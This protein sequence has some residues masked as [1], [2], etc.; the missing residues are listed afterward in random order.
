[1]TERQSNIILAL[2]IGAAIVVTCLLAYL[3][4]DWF[5][6]FGGT[7]APTPAPTPPPAG[8]TSWSEVEAAGKIVVGTSADYPPFAYYDENFQLTGLD[9]TLMREIGQRL[10]VDVEFEDKIF[11]SLLT[12]LQVGES[13][14]AIGA[15]AITP[16]RQGQVDF[17]DVYYVS[18]D[19][20]LARAD[21]SITSITAVEQMADKRVGV[22]QGSAFENWLQTSLVDTGLMPASNLLVYQKATD[23][24]RD[25]REQRVDLVVLDFA[26]AETAVANGGVKLVGQG[27]Q[28]QVFAIAVP[29]GAITLLTRINTALTDLRNSGRLAQ[30]IEEYIGLLPDQIPPTPP[31]QLTAVPPPQPT[32]TPAGCIDD[33]S[34]VQDL[35]YDDQNMTNPPTLQ[36]GQPFSKGWRVRNTGT[37]LWDATY[38]LAYVGGNT[39]AAQMGG[40]PRPVQ[41]IVQP[42]QTYDFYVDLFAPPVPGTYQGFWSMR[43]TAGKQFGDRVWVGIR[44][45]A[46]A[47]VTP[48]PTQTP[49]TDITFT[50]D[51]TT[52]RQGE[53]VAFNW[54]VR[55]ARAVYF[56]AQGQRWE[57][58]GVPPQGN[59]TVCP[60]STTTYYLRVVKADN[61][62]ETRQITVNVIPAPDAPLIE[63]FATNPQQITLGQCVSLQW[64]V[65]GEVSRIR[66]LANGGVLWDGAPLRG[67][68]QNCPEASGTVNYTLEAGGAG[69]SS[70]AQQ[71]VNVVT[72]ATATPVPTLPPQS[73]IIDAFAVTPGQIAVGECVTVNWSTSGGTSR[74][75]IRREGVPLVSNGGLNGSIQDC[76]TTVGTVRYELEAASI[77]NEF[78]TQS[79]LLGVSEPAAS[80]PLAD[81]SWAL[82]GLDESGLINGSFVGITFYADGTL[83]GDSGCNDYSSSYIVSGDNISVGEIASSSAFCA[84]PAGV[85]EQE[86]SYWSA[87]RSVVRFELQSSTLLVLFD[88]NGRER[89][90]FVLR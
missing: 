78:V 47:T 6:D 75:N 76:P 82:I 16:E 27:L 77:T 52:V 67:S 64:V 26:P 37:C 8:D 44:V 50:A 60:A 83:N 18:Q 21:S 73:P 48:Q 39:P 15:I 53:C 9:I 3:W 74:V 85:M 87:L 58:N 14:A 51:K 23:A 36:P 31:P 89:L 54:N 13:H 2:L 79:A 17:S 68:L 81:T 66:I 61:T 42:G 10:G 63:Q 4:L 72:P 12:S 32:A 41:G 28:T 33:M 20:I 62:V 70:L 40:Q 30:I 88:A 11:E 46:P 29:K 1:M 7:S 22:E 86:Q 45:P 57:Y 24:V 56:Y 5:F 43:N 80:N 84:T 25:L 59:R 35:N 71:Y 38:N 49:S 69:G 55:N 90:R 65:S 34:Y 19:G